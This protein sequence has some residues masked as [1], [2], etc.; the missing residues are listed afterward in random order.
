MLA[1]VLAAPILVAAQPALGARPPL[2]CTNKTIAG[3]QFRFCTG[4]VLS[5]DGSVKLDVDVTLPATGTKFPLI[6]MLHGL[7][8]NKVLFEALKD[9]LSDSPCTAPGVVCSA[10]DITGSGGQYHMNNLWFASRGYAVLNYTARG[11]RGV[12]AS[13]E[14]LCQNDRAAA[15]FDALLYPVASTGA[16]PACLP[17]V[18]HRKHEVVDAQ[19]L[20][21]GLVD[22]SL[23]SAEATIDPKRVGVGGVSYGGGTSWLLSRR[24]SWRTPGGKLVLLAAT[25]PVIGWTDLVQALLP[26]GRARDDVMPPTDVDL[27][28]AQR[29]GVLKESYVDAFYKGL[30]LASH[31]DTTG[32][33][34]LPGYLTKWRNTI[35]LGE[36]YDDPAITAIVDDAVRKLLVNRSAFYVQ[37][38]RPLHVTPTLAVQGWTDEV[39]PATQVLNMYNRLQV[40]RFDS[41]G[42]AYPLN[43]YFGDWGHPRS[44]GKSDET[45]YIAGLVNKWYDH[46]LRGRGASPGAGIE[47]RTTICPDRSAAGDELGALY[48]A[49]RWSRLQDGALEAGDLSMSA[50]T[51]NTPSEDPHAADL[52]P[53]QLLNSSRSNKCRSTDVAVDEDNAAASVEVTDA[54]T[55]LGMP[56]I[57]LL[58]DPSDSDMYVAAHLWD[59]DPDA[60]DPA[61]AQTLVDR[62][63][64]RLGSDGPQVVV[65]QLNG[66]TYEFQAGHELKLELTAD[67]SPTFRRFGTTGDMTVRSIDISNVSLSVP[68]ANPAK[69]VPAGP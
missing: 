30:E 47:V 60:T 54:F 9:G 59:V 61:K 5:K 39:F 41:G 15:D 33:L 37:R 28:M 4:L 57:S 20:I 18:P 68:R 14:T 31:R 52:E 62:G 45:Q 51:L 24:N 50:T 48:R 7:G 10:A 66:N 11:H 23:L 36:P 58:A 49:D 67:D 22:G 38:S 32:V 64:Y 40:P 3:E 16:S 21:S 12:A 1:V 25:V 42:T 55:M 44:Q 17:Q 43:M 29:V 56:E 65:F 13:P 19:W 53:V 2:R 8:Q 6:A 35:K 34:K 63:V 27:R 69:L 26:N 46:Y